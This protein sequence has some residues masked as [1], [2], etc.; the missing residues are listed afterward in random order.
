MPRNPEER[1]TAYTEGIGT[2]G[3]ARITLPSNPDVFTRGIRERLRMLPYMDSLHGWN[4]RV[5]SWREAMGHMDMK[6]KDEIS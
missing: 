3:G 4:N 2:P 1:A 5:C 6:V